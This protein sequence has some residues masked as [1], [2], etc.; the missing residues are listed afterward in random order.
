MQRVDW[1]NVWIFATPRGT[2]GR[3]GGRVEVEYR[4]LE[5]KSQE[6]HCQS[7]EN[8]AKNIV[9][10]YN[11]AVVEGSLNETNKSQHNHHN[12]RERWCSTY[13]KH[14][15]KPKSYIFHYETGKN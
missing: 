5:R 4:K 11:V 7:Q 2:C 8:I 1:E 6:N 3:E 15:L 12:T 13:K 14:A 9:Y 10:K